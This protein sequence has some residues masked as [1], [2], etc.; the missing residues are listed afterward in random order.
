MF[1]N[2]LFGRLF[3]YVHVGVFSIYPNYVSGCSMIDHNS[4][5]IWKLTPFSL[6]RSSWYSSKT[7]RFKVVLP[8]FPVLHKPSKWVHLYAGM[9]IKAMIS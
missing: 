2:H 9:T 8:T 6:L 4:Y 7:R 5:K 1:L 3:K